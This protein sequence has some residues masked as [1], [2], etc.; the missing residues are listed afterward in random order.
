MFEE[1][2]IWRGGQ[3]VRLGIR[4]GLDSRYADEQRPIESQFRLCPEEQ[5]IESAKPL[6]LQ[7]EYVWQFRLQS[8][9]DTVDF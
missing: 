2:L 1:L 8:F 6:S 7:H 4:S 9:A 3:G 5:S